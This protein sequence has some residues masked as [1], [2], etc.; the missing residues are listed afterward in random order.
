MSDRAAQI[1]R[2]ARDRYIRQSFHPHA[3][4]SFTIRT[5]Q[6]AQKHLDAAARLRRV[7]AEDRGAFGKR[8]EFMRETMIVPENVILGVAQ[9]LGIAPKDIFKREQNERIWK[10]L[11][12]SDYKRLRTV[13]DKR[14]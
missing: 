9:K 4:G 2:R 6:D 13:T 3:D 11:E 14:L 1:L 10:E 7:D 8:R 12:G 5:H